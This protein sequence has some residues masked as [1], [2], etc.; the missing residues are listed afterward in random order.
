MQFFF[1]EKREEAEL[2][3]SVCCCITLLTINA[4]F[5]SKNESKQ[6]MD[7]FL[8]GVERGECMEVV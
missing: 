3:F 8:K 1:V 6:V 7:E 5:S 2:L 4:L